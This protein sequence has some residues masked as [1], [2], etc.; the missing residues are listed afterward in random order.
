MFTTNITNKRF[1][2]VSKSKS[3]DKEKLYYITLRSSFHVEIGQDSE[4]QL[5]GFKTSILVT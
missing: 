5:C 2:L 1:T 3:A 4:Q